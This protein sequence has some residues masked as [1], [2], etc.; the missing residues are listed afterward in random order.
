[1]RQA[2]QV[3]GVCGDSDITGSYACRRMEP[4]PPP[5]THYAKAVAHLARFVSGKK[6]GGGGSVTYLGHAEPGR[7]NPSIGG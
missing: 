3:G 6:G 2:Y 1:M 4:P 7:P 5:P